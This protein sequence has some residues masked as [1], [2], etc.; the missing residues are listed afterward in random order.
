MTQ[1]EKWSGRLG[2]VLAA[3]GSAVGLGNLWKFPYIAWQNE[4][5][6]FV[7]VYL[8]CIVVVGVP[9]MMSELVIGRRSQRSPVAAF[10]VLGGRGWGAAGWLAVS[11]GVVI[12]AFYSVIAGWSLQSFARCLRWSVEGY[13]PPEAGAFAAFLADGPRQVGLG[14][15]FLVLTALVV[16]RGISGG[17]EK[18]TRVLMPVLFGIMLYLLVTASTLPGFDRAIGLLFRP[19]WSKLSSHGVLE[20]L[21]HAFFTL[22]LGMGAMVTYGSYLRR[23]TSIVQISITV[24]VL[25]TFVA[26]AACVIMFAVI[27]SV[28]DLESTMST[29]GAKSTV[30]MLFVTLPRMFYTEMAGGAVIAPLFYVLVAFAALSSTISLLEVTVATAMDRLAWTR[31]RATIVA[32]ALIGLFSVGCALSLGASTRLSEMK[33]FGRF[34]GLDAIVTR[35]KSGLLAIFDHVSANWLLPLAGLTV[36][37]FAGW[38]LDA[39]QSFDELFPGRRVPSWVFRAWRFLS[40]YVCPA[41]IGWILVD[42]L[43]GGDFS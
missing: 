1:R 39:E 26:L 36:T 37:M 5:G 41:A 6:A 32:T 21:G 24:A 31:A 11:A 2:F 17:I 42:V 9:V 25:D 10:A 27:L 16:V 30:G 19:E 35:D 38:A 13:T 12:L 22:S 23:D 14:L 29:E 3:A 4:G 33:L 18:A 43:R 40:R 20:A 34:E 7:L 28:P 15:G 8:A